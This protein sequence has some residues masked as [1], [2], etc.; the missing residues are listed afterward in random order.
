MKIWYC[1]IPLLLPLYGVYAQYPMPRISSTANL[2]RALARYPKQDTTRIQMQLRLARE[3]GNSGNNKGKTIAI[4][5]LSLARKLHLPGYEAAAL[6][7]CARFV[8][9]AGDT[10]A[11]KQLY[12]TAKDINERRRNQWGV[13]E[14]LR[15]LGHCYYRMSQFSKAINTH[16]QAI[17]YCTRVN[18]KVGIAE[19]YGDIGKVFLYA[20]MDYPKAI[21]YYGLALAV[22]ERVGVQDKVAATFNNMGIAHLESA[23]LSQALTCFQR[24]L[25]IS[26]T[27]HDDDGMA[28][29]LGCIGNVYQALSN[30]PKAIDYYQRAL[31]LNERLK[32]TRRMGTIIRKI[33]D[34][35]RSLND[36][37]RALEYFQRALAISRQLQ[38]VNGIANNLNNIGSVYASMGDF[39][40]AVSYFQQAL[41][42]Y[43][44]AGNENG[45][46]RTTSDIGNACLR[47]SNYSGAWVQLQRALATSQRL[48][49]K[50]SIAENLNLLSQLLALAPD[51]A[52]K[53]I[54]VPHESR[55]PKARAY[56]QQAL[57]IAQAIGNVEQ[58][59]NALQTAATI[60]AQHQQ[61]QQAYQACKAFLILQDSIQGEAIARQTMRKEIQYEFSK[62]ED[63]LRFRQQLT[64]QE[65]ER[66]RLLIIQQQKDL[67]A[68]NTQRNLYAAS[69]LLLILLAAAIGLGLYR[70]SREKRKSDNLLHNILPVS[71]AAELKA[72]GQTTAKLYQSVSVLFSDFVNFTAI[73][74]NMPPEDL[75][76]ELN[77]HFSAFDDIMARYGLEKI[78]TIGD[79]YLA[80]CGLPQPNPHHAR[81]TVLAAHEMIAYLSQ[82]KSTFKLRI[83][84]NSGSVVAGVVGV[85][86]FAYD[87][88]GDT[89]NTAARMEQNSHPG[90]INISEATY[91]LVKNEF[92]CEHR[93]KVAAK[94]KGEI[95]M[96]FVL[97]AG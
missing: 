90:R 25:E 40:R 7:F 84:I 22:Y 91:Q 30:Y 57:A 93:G 24:A 54:S 36:H 33:G 38:N 19:N 95:D 28:M 71:V 78:K 50:S 49:I 34:I 29:N 81:L 14:N 26:G 82:A 64:Q 73:S 6:H 31:T 21:Y 88:W 17:T 85:K 18:N 87:I 44:K 92:D 52:L 96:Y 46:A 94:N 80:V 42:I 55:Y 62:K 35:Y 43:E 77:R 83:G 23:D 12:E 9:D 39:S 5:A 45:I 59:K 47:V 97:Q 4:N 61:Y 3:Y 65:L 63:S 66:Q 51:T 32:N 60:Y 8:L 11:A 15:G 53:R 68:K 74:E 69:A 67:S 2:E 89:V 37:A 56:N 70:T 75:V 41:F 58:Q 76:A 20:L 1:L 72:T 10:G 48:G 27:L 13:A 86:K 16:N 79:A